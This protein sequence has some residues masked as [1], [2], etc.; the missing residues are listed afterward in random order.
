[1]KMIGKS[2]VLALLA[3]SLAFVAACD[4]GEEEAP[5]QTFSCTAR[6]S[7]TTFDYAVVGSQLLVNGGVESWDR[8]GRADD[9]SQVF[10]T[11]H[12][13]TDSS[14]VG[15]TSLDIEIRAARVTAIADCDFGSVSTTATASAAAIVDGTT[16]TILEGDED[17][18]YVT[19]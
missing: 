5:P 1:M 9:E 7:P 8:V 4:G 18:Q 3:S 2:L 11:W 14:S 19:R 6:I 17:T 16:V 10:G 13:A 12:V 15:T